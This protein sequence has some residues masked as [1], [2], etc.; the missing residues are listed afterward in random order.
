MDLVYS[1][2]NIKIVQLHINIIAHSLGP[3]LI[4]WLLQC[5]PF[6]TSWMHVDETNATII[7]E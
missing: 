5:T 2:S 1:E 6:Y 4:A 3:V 7:P